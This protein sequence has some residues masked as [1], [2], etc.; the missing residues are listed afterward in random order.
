MSGYYH[1][2]TGQ[3]IYY[4]PTNVL[5]WSLAV[6]IKKRPRLC[7]EMVALRQMLLLIYSPTLGRTADIVC[8]GQH[9]LQNIYCFHLIS[10][11]LLSLSSFLLSPSLFLLPANSMQL[12]HG[13]LAAYKKEV[14]FF[15]DE[16]PRRCS[17]MQ[18]SISLITQL[19]R[20]M[21]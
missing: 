5:V 11:P 7:L 4:L 18:I 3:T 10:S 14:S 15:S 2:S 8:Q 17:L 12:P 21:Y 19:C 9:L 20:I 1:D 13:F 6:G 16:A